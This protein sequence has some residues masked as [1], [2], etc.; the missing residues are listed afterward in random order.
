MATSR[1]AHTS[2]SEWDANV[3]DRISDP[4]LSWAA[5]VL[6]RLELRGDEVVLDAGC[7]SGRVTELLIERL[8]RGRVIA[9]DG[10]ESMVAMARERLNDRADVRQL[11]LAWLDM[12]EEVDL[13]YSNAVFHWIL[14]HDNLFRRLHAALRP[15]GRI[16]AQCGGAGNVAEATEAI[17][18][19][20]ADPRY[21]RHFEGMEQLWNFSSPE[22]MTEVLRGAGFEPIECWDERKELVPEEPLDYLAASALGPFL[23]R[24]PDKL[25]DEFVREVAAEIG[26]PLTLVYVR[27]NIEA[28]R[29]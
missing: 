1:P 16:V 11:D 26:D 5:E 8:P 28:T 23:Q 7:G 21:G 6:G 15:G 27:L 4:Q 17:A 22:R 29:P 2:P 12:Q 18:K 3:Y 9:V 20:A 10:S 25:G 19:V 14:D 24:L 13:V